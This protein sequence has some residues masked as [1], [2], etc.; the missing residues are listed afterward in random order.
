MPQKK[1][2]DFEPEKD[3]PKGHRHY[4]KQRCQAWSYNNGR[5]CLA[6]ANTKERSDKC[7]VHGAKSLKGIAHYNL[8]SGKY[9]K[10]L[11]ARIDHNYEQARKNPDY[12]KLEDEIALIDSRLIELTEKIGAQ[13]SSHIFTDLSSQ[14]KKME[15]A[16]AVLIRAQNI[17][18]KEQREKV[19]EKANIEFSESLTEITRLVKSGSR[20][21]YIWDDITDLIEKRRRLVETERRLLIDMQMLINLED[22]FLRF[23]ILM[24]SIRRNVRDRHIRSAIQSDFNRAIGR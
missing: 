5:Q 20:D 11:P 2:L 14:V 18:N 1:P 17:V 8:K 24:E 16:Q 23:D 9:S 6:L 13:A 3:F 19:R 15:S 10:H 7:N 12:L 22:A 4:G 21:W